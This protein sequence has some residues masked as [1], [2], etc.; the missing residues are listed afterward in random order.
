MIC[1]MQ[2]K[3]AIEKRKN[4]DFSEHAWEKKTRLIGQRLTRV[5]IHLRMR[6]EEH[7]SYLDICIVLRIKITV[8]ARARGRINTHLHYSTRK[9]QD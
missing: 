1:T 9:S 4:Q 5:K 7:D 2:G 6:E 8:S 3:A